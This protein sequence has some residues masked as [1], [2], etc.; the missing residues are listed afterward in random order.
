MNLENI[1]NNT[2]FTRDEL[3]FLLS[4]EGD[5]MKKLLDRALEVK[6][7]EIGNEVYLRGLIEYSN[8]CVKS[9]LYCGVRSKILILIATP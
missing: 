8:V 5:D 7:R 2:L 4:L 1:L 6:L 3:I 9:C